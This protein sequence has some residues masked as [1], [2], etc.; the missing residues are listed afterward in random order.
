MTSLQQC[1]PMAAPRVYALG[2]STMASLLGP[3][4]KRMLKRD[5]PE[6]TFAQWGK[7]S[8]GLARPDFHDWPAQIP[9]INRR[10]KPDLFVVSLGTNDYQAVRLRSGAWVRSGTARW[11]QVYASRVRKMLDLMSGPERRRLV[12]WVGPTAF[13][14]KGSY[15]IGPEIT[16]I[17]RREIAAFGGPAI[18]VDAFAATTDGKNRPRDTFKVP[19]KRGLKAMRGR[20]GIHLT[21]EAVRALMGR[22][23]ADHILQCRKDNAS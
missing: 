10:H 21:A 20:D 13:P 17:L 4:L 9:K 14:G 11:K 5:W 18:L 19:G 12:V 8:S 7:P 16:K 2:S 15:T 3:A 22:P 6:A 1:L 23:A